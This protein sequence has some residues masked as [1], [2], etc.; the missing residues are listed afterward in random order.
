DGAFQKLLT[1]HGSMKDTEEDSE[2]SPAAA[3]PKIAKSKT[4]KDKELGRLVTTETKESGSVKSGVL[5]TYLKAMQSVPTAA[6]V[7]IMFGLTQLIAVMSEW[8]LAYWADETES[9]E[10]GHGTDFYLGLYVAIAM[11]TGI[12]TFLRQLGVLSLSLAASE[13]LHDQMWEAVLRCPLSFFQSTPVGRVTA[14][15]ARDVDTIDQTLADTV[16]R[17][18]TTS[19]TAFVSLIIIAVIAPWFAV[20]L[21]PLLYMYYRIMQVYRCSSRELKRLHAV[22]GSPIYANFSE[23]LM[24]LD[25]IRAYGAGRQ[26]WHKCHG[27][28]NTSSRAYFPLKMLERWV[29]LRLEMV[30]NIITMVVCILCVVQRGSSSAGLAGLIIYRSVSITSILGFMVRATIESENQLTAVERIME[31]IKSL[32]A[33][34]PRVTSA[35]GELS[36]DWPTKGEIEFENLTVTYRSGL[37]P[38]LQD[39]SALVRGGERVGVVGRTGA[40]KSTL[41]T[42]LFRLVEPSSGCI[43]IDGVDTATLGLHVLRS[44]LGIVPQDPVLFSGSVRFNL[45][46]LAEGGAEVSSNDARLVEA[47]EQVGLK[48]SVKLDDNVAEYGS[49]F[50][51]GQR[52]LMCMVRCILQKPRV[53][54]LDEATS[55]VDYVTDSMIQTTIRTAFGPCTVLTIA[56]RLNTI[57]DSNRI[58]C[59]DAGRIQDFDSPLSLLE[60]PGSIYYELVNEMGQDAADGIKKAA[61][62]VAVPLS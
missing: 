28:V 61:Q 7:V 42:A 2:G 41:M 18:L 46:P 13:K 35:D 8:W 62:M 48:E 38:A 39:V 4:A 45:E 47:I 9:S 10:E 36:S 21:I 34:A 12:T 20:G 17:S 53:L 51:A 26:F 27:L 60:K 29:A 31:Y 57:A 55:S 40:G 6:F 59:F 52:Q 30:A 23:T 15:F 25:S 14:R 37:E 3:T 58:M 50:S 56:H 22:T 54:V 1:Q 24:G 43:R 32:P 16:T 49:N 11:S 19:S 33:E 44:R 5:L